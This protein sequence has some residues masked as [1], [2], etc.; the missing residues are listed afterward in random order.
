MKTLPVVFGIDA[1]W[2]GNKFGDHG[3]SHQR[4][5]TCVY[6]CIRRGGGGCLKGLPAQGL[7]GLEGTPGALTHGLQKSAQS[8]VTSEVRTFLPESPCGLSHS[9]DI[10]FIPLLDSSIRMTLG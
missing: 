9:H 2:S 3:T 10:L 1:R 6:V 5:T 7:S 8:Q 4:I